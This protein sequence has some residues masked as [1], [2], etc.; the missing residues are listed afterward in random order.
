M[1]VGPT[2]DRGF[3]DKKLEPSYDVE[4]IAIWRVYAII[5]EQLADYS[6]GCAKEAATTGMPIVRP[7]FLQWPVQKPCWQDWQT[8]MYGPD[9][10]V[11]AI[12]QK[13][14]KSHTLYLPKGSDWVD[15]WG[16]KVYKG[17][18][19]ITVKA[20]MH[21]IPFFVRKGADLK[22]P[23]LNALYAESLKIAAKKPDLDALQRAEFGI[24]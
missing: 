12:W 19:Y 21:K 6:Y 17:G 9:I 8:Y 5:H 23:D 4:L 14:K 11:S 2:N 22:F 1:E 24:D 15:A 13:G 3:W 10:L 20:P 7:L 16:G 18:Q